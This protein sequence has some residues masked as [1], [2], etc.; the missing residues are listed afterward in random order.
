MIFSKLLV[1]IDG[2]EPSRAA[3]RTAVSLAR[4]QGASIVFCHALE[5]VALLHAAE[6]PAIDTGPAIEQARQR[7]STLI[8]GA[9]RIANEAGVQAKGSM[10]EA[11][12]VP[13]IVAQAKAQAADLIVI[14]THGRGGLALAFLGSTAQGVL[15][16]AGVPVLVVTAHERALSA[17]PVESAPPA[18]TTHRRT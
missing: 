5:T 4:D 9:I 13:F 10:G 8:D 3:V 14:G 15:R 17:A 16:S 2:S 6:Q 1:P 7:V 12:A 18:T 11:D